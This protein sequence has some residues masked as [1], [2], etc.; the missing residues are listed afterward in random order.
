LICNH[1]CCSSDRLRRVQFSTSIWD[2]IVNSAG[3][4]MW[5]AWATTRGAADLCTGTIIACNILDLG[6]GGWDAIGRAVNPD[7]S[8]RPGA[9]GAS[10]TFGGGPVG[11][12]RSISDQAGKL[13]PN[14][15]SPLR[16]CSRVVSS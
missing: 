8:R 13:S 16:D 4:C 2:P 7:W 11:R 6:R 9:R 15:G 14:I 1:P 3:S 5:K 12:P 10:K